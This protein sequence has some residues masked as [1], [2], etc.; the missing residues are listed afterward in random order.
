[1][2]FIVNIGLIFYNF[3]LCCVAINLL[4]PYIMLILCIIVNVVDVQAAYGNLFSKISV[5]DEKPVVTVPE[6]FD[7]DALVADPTNPKVFFEVSIGDEVKGK[8][9][10]SLFNSVCPKT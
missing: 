9:V 10:M 8:I 4:H 3:D 6:T 5:Y 2:V 1:M 7:M